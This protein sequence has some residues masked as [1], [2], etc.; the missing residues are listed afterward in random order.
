MMLTTD[1][2]REVMAEEVIEGAEEELYTFHHLSLCAYRGSSGIAT[3]R[4]EGTI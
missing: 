1:A 2:G 3:I 4:F